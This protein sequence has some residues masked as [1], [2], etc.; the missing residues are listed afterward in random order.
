MAKAKVVIIGGG[1]GGLYAARALAR[2]PVEITL[3]DRRNHHLFQPLLYQ[4]ATATLNASDIAVP[5]RSVLRR[6]EN[7]RV[8]LG[9]ATRVDPGARRVHLADGAELP[10]DFLLVATGATHS[11]FGHDAWA[12]A[13]PGLKSIDDA[14]EIRRRVF[15]AFESAERIAADDDERRAL[16]TFVIIG[17]GPTGVEMA[18]ALAEIA[19]HSLRGEF[20]SIDPAQSRIILI[21]GMDRVLPSYPEVLS[22]AAARRLQKLG[23]ELHLGRRVT[24]VDE[25]GVTTGSERLETRTVVWAAGVAASP[26]ARSLGVPLDR[27]GR[28]LV[29]P[30]LTIPGHDEVFVAGDLAAIEQDGE[31]VPGVSPAA[32]QAGR[33]VAAAIRQTLAGKPRKP[34]RYFDKGSFAVIGRG[35]AVGSLLNR[36]KL[37]GLV[38]WL[39]W[40]FIHLYF[41]IGFRNR[42]LVLIDWAYSFLFFRRGVRLITGEDLGEKLLG[43][44]PAD[45][46]RSSGG[47]VR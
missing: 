34:F 41:L 4:V 5:I 3:V 13:A 6:Q 28:V 33:H 19:R 17:A 14:L 40:L 24:G 26:L 29:R 7:V 37:R 21:E 15:L 16:L 36:F 12:E 18:G 43:A 45:P 22:A 8:L 30:D 20:R 44:A 32:M 39:G 9:E 10:Y 46:I 2:A 42:L 38:A 11:Y 47:G 27:A 31:L 1:F 35:A 23:V 25:H